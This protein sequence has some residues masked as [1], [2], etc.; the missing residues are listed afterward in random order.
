MNLNS[1]F[2]LLSSFSIYVPLLVGAFN[3]KKL[4]KPYH[5]LFLLIFIGVAIEIV[6]DIAKD[7][8]IN[9]LTL[10]IYTF[11]ETIL[12]TLIYLKFI[13]SSK[14]KRFVVIILLLLC[15]FFL[16]NFLLIQGINMLNSYSM[17]L[18]C[19]FMIVL[20]ARLFYQIIINVPS[21]SLIKS[22]IFW[23]NTAI[24]IYFSL[25][26]FTFLFSNMLYGKLNSHFF[27]FRLWNIHGITNIL[28]N[29]CFAITL[30]L[31]GK[32]ERSA[33]TPNEII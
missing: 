4:K 32:R 28:L 25:N 33:V 5:L 22:E 7:I 13:D 20:S 16:I 9:K 11:A 2:S 29:F 31:A 10:N 14:W 30:W 18:E 17:V 19:G 23:F 8:A 21:E 27:G 1:T 26:I 3:I 15:S 6:N 12:L 24:F